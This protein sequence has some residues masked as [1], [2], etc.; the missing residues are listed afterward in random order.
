M[1]SIFVYFSI[2]INYSLSL[3]ADS[4]FKI[5]NEFVKYKTQNSQILNTLLKVLKL[6]HKTTSKLKNIIR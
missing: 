3:Y 4:I 5:K 6:N 1:C 2:N